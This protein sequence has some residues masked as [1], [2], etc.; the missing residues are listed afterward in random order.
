LVE[1]YEVSRS[2]QWY[3]VGEAGRSDSDYGSFN[4]ICR[5]EYEHYAKL[6]ADLLNKHDAQPSQTPHVQDAGY[7]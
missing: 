4:E 6:I 2:G 3:T 7:R 1:T 5:C